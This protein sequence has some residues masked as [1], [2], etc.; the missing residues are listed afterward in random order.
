[1]PTVIAVLWFALVVTVVGTWVIPYLQRDIRDLRDR[2]VARVHRGQSWTPR[3][4]L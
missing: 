1:M 4:R 3:G 2:G